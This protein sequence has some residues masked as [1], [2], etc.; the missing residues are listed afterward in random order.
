MARRRSQRG[1]QRRWRGGS[2][3]RRPAR[4][5]A[6]AA[7]GAARVPSAPAAMRRA[8]ARRVAAPAYMQESTQTRSP[9]SCARRPLDLS[10]YR[11]ALSRAQTLPATLAVLGDC[12]RL[13]DGCPARPPRRWSALP[14]PSLWWGRASVSTRRGW[15]RARAPRSTPRASELARIDQR[16]LPVYTILL[17]LYKEKPSTVRA[18]FKALSELDYPKHKLDGLALIEADDDHTQRARSRPSGDRHGYAC[19]RC[20]RAFRVP[21]RG[22]CASGC[23]TP[24]AAS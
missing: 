10:A 9:A 13:P 1:R 22:Q 11:T 21:S 8:N 20:P 7:G 12:G 4:R 2:R 16:A 23:A 6:G 18:L 19:Y 24:R 14:P 17:P 15:A 5:G 3:G